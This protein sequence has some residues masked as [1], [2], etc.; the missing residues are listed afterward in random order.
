MRFSFRKRG[1]ICRADGVDCDADG[2]ATSGCVGGATIGTGGLKCSICVR[3][4]RFGNASSCLGLRFGIRIFN[5]PATLPEVEMQER[6]EETILTSSGCF[7]LRLTSLL[8]KSFLSRS[9]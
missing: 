7:R 3:S 4:G 8:P 5:A 6:P 1:V 9:S 2:L